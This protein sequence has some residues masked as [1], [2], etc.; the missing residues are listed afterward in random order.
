MQNVSLHLINKTDSARRNHLVEQGI[1]VHPMTPERVKDLRLVLNG[2]VQPAEIQVEATD[3]PGDVRWVMVTA[4]V[5]AEAGESREYVLADAPDLP[6]DIPTLS[7]TELGDTISIATPSFTM[8]LSGTR[9]MRVDIDGKK[10]I[11]GD[12]A[13]SVMADAQSFVSG[14]RTIH[15]VP[16]GFTIAEKSQSRALITW[17]GK[18]HPDVYRE[19]TGIDTR[20]YMDCE[21]E[22]RVYAASPVVRCK[23]ILTSNFYYQGAMER[24]AF[25][26]PLSPDSEIAGEWRD[27]KFGH[28]ARVDS[29]SGAFSVTAPFIEDVGKGAGIAVERLEWIY[30][31]PDGFSV[32]LADPTELPYEGDGKQPGLPFISAMRPPVFKTDFRLIV[33]GIDPPPDEGC[34]TDHPQIHR[35]WLHGMSR[36]FEFSIVLDN[37]TSLVDSELSPMYFTIDPQ[38]YSDT[39]ALPERGGPVAFGEFENEVVLSADWLEEHQWKGSL[40][41]GE[42]WREYCLD[43]KQGIEEAG[44][45]NSS[46]GVFYHWLRTG[47]E[48]YLKAAK[49]SMLAIYDLTMCK[50]HDGIGPFM[51]TRRFLF[52]REN[53]HHPRYQRIAGMMRP[54]HI[55]C[56]KRMRKHATDVVRHFAERY[57]DTDGAPMAASYSRP[58]ATAERCNE[59][60]MAQFCE[61]L[62]LAWHETGDQFFLDKAKLMAGWAADQMDSMFGSQKVEANWNIQFVNRG[63]LAVWLAT[64]E[65]RW[66]DAYVKIC[67]S[68]LGVVPEHAGYRDLVLWEVHFVVYFAWHF[69]EAH[70]MTGDDQM[71]KDYIK[72]LNAELRRQAPDG[73]FPYVT[74]YIPQT[75]QWNSYYDQKTC[76]AYLPVLAS[77]MQ[78][79][80]I[81]RFEK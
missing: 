48:K 14:T 32:F 78:E 40:Y 19:Y 16:E 1:P 80:G 7:V 38:H 47:D 58:D 69:A 27:G 21:I 53:W 35:T 2:K 15:F 68:I 45:G 43:R 25:A 22:M 46:L 51:H 41:F 49:R 31:E 62:V 13:F 28:W 42:W 64:G 65:D 57:V 6:Q 11:D 60:A 30:D 8:S 52:D 5:D 71:L 72:V 77:R 54:S 66:K 73:S 36:S 50:Q 17:R 4:V 37:S 55:F 75:S 39:E 29:P 67:R 33:G 24:Y 26:L 74:T 63:L 3:G 59:A 12:L 81:G 9:M 20:R 61:T 18:M 76:A 44:S 56:D 10:V 34:G 79:A 23:M 70:K